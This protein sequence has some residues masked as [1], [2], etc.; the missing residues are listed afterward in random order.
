VGV[1]VEQLDDQAG[2]GV[3]TADHR[4]DVDPVAPGLAEQHIA[5]HVVPGHRDQ[6]WPHTELGEGDRLV[7][8]LA[9]ELFEAVR[10]VPGGAGG[11]HLV[12][13]QHEVAGELADDGRHE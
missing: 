9:A 6:P 3:P 2:Q 4:G 11:G 13:G 8:A 5:D 10:G 1:G 12:D 7:G